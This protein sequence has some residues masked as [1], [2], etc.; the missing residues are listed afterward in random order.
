MKC[1][2]F[3]RL[4][5]MGA[6]AP[7]F[8]VMVGCLTMAV[9]AGAADDNWAT[10]F[11]TKL[12]IKLEKSFDS[13]GPDAWDPA[14][15]PLVFVTSEGPGYGGLLS[16]VKLPGPA[17]FDANSR[18][19][20]ASQSYDVLAMGW[21]SVFE[22][23]GLG[24]S[25]DGKWIYLPTGEGSFGTKE[26]G[27][28]LIINARTLK[29]DKVL[30][31][32]SN[33]HHAKAFRRPD[34]KSLVLVE[35]FADN[36][37]PTFI[38]DPDNDNKVVGGW[39]AE[40]LG[41]KTSYLNF[42]SPDGKEVFVGAGSHHAPPAMPGATQSAIARIDTATWKRIGDLIPV[43]DANTVW[44][45]FTSD[46]KFACISGAM[47]S[48]V[49]KFDR[50]QNKIVAYSRAGVEGPYGVHLGWDDRHLYMV[51][52]GESSHNRGKV[53]GKV[54]LALMGKPGGAFAQD[55]YTTNCI[56]GDHATLHPVP[57]ANELW[58]TCNSSF[59]VVI[60]DLDEKKVSARLRMPHG[61]STHSGA[62]V[63]YTGWNGEVVSDQNGLHGSAL[64]A[65]R[66]LLSAS[67][68][69]SGSLQNNGAPAS[70]H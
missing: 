48:N 59:E 9:P 5:R 39:T 61:G 25:M 19:V 8:A 49:V 20:V 64:A 67:G 34:G 58:I 38:L 15:H 29:L 66:K 27:R 60:F 42:V 4:R 24:V 57:D 31:L 37:Q 7:I 32:Q 70:V 63:K 69:K 36:F 44:A 35:N 10:P 26:A 14:K 45:A 2:L 54:D 55:Q 33:A 16:G 50:D 47:G 43:P 12:G 30:K 65:K 22:P 18:E 23:H 28:L 46:N 13:K 17:I 3:G 51:G 1:H 53:L 68:S 41:G 6:L 11:A 56:R 40:E 21:K 62:F 52:K